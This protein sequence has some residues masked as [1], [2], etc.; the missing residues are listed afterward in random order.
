M[1]QLQQMPGD[2]AAACQIPDQ[3]QH[4]VRVNT[5]HPD[6]WGQEPAQGNSQEAA[7]LRGVCAADDVIT[8]GL[9]PEQEDFTNS[10]QIYCLCCF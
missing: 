10:K 5:N 8:E 4:Q 1:Q 6:D 7:A 3:S 9:E 2:F